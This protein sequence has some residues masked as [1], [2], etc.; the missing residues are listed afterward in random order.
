MSSSFDYDQWELEL[1]QDLPDLPDLP[2]LPELQGKIVRRSA[3]P[4]TRS[5]RDEFPLGCS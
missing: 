1:M 3:A 5:R 4:M 2:L